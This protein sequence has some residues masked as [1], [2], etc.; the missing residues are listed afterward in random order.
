MPFDAPVVAGLANEL[1]DVLPVKIDKIYQPA[2]DEFIFGCYGGGQSYKLLISLNSQFARFHFTNQSKSNPAQPSSFCMLLRKHFGGSK[3]VRAIGIPFERILKLTFE[4]YDPVTG[5][6]HKD[7]LAEFTGKSANLILVDAQGIIIDSW[8]RLSPRNPGDRD[9]SSGSRYQLPSTGARWQPVTLQQEDFETLVRQ[10]PPDIS[11]E[12]LLLTHW[13]GLSSLAAKTVIHAAAL[14]IDSIC[15]Q[16]TPIET[17]RLYQAFCNW[18]AQV[19]SGAF[20]PVGFYDS[21]GKLVDCWVFSSHLPGSDLSVQPAQTLQGLIAASIGSRQ[22]HAFFQEQRGQLLRQIAVHLEK[23]RKKLAKQLEEARQADK[24]DELRIKGELLTIYGHQ[25]TK[26]MTQAD[27][28]NHYDSRGE[29]LRVTLNPALT[30]HENAQIYFKKYQKAKKGQSAIAVQIEKTLAVIN[31]LESLE[32]LAENAA[33]TEDLDLIREEW[34]AKPEIRQTRPSSMKK[35]NMETPAKPRQFITA[36]GHQILVGRNNLQNDRLTFK[37]ASPSDWWFHTQKIPGS[38]VIL[39]VA[40]GMTV[41]DEVLN[42]ACQLAVYFSKA[43]H[44]TKV[45]V[46][47][48]QRKNVKKPPG[49]KPGFVIYDFFKTVI[50]TP[51]PNN[52]AQLGIRADNGETF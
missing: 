51:D 31:Y 38:H 43:R 27:L 24:G 6:S 20:R 14:P 48:T 21:D 29:L 4:V 49:S 35:R 52:L 5:L 13:Y 23:N 45:P 22:E 12:N 17:A 46:D 42:Y 1:Q 2:R 34:D 7:I 9:I 44:S 10:V 37:I 36:A 47:Y 15:G 41:D 33:S 28:N 11:L 39:K 30:P 8:R 19:V 32:T 18:S 16:L 3:L 40:P 25:L 26:G 50:I